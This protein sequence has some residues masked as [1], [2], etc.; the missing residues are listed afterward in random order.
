MIR[1]D[2]DYRIMT[3]QL[4]QSPDDF[5]HSPEVLINSIAIEFC[6]LLVM[7]GVIFIDDVPELV[8]NAI[9]APEILKERI[10]VV[11]RGYMNTS[12][13]WTRSSGV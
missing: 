9:G 3:C 7:P 11:S 10:P 4:D 5:I 13:E 6:F 2:Q 1:C 12:A 8:L